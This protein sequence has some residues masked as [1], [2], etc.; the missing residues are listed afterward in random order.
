MSDQTDILR[1]LADP[2]T[3][4][5]APARVEHVQTHISHVFLAGPYVYK[6]KK[7][8]RLPFVDQSTVALRQALCLE[9]VR[10]NRRLAAP[11]YLGVIP[12]TRGADGPVRLG[13]AG[14]P[15]DHVVWMRRLPAEAMLAQRIT[16]GCAH[17][18]MMQELAAVL[19]AFHA[20]APR[21][22]DVSAHASPEAL[23]ATWDAT[24]A[25]AGRFAG[26]LLSPAAHRVLAEFGPAFLR[27]HDTL[28]RA[29]QRAE[30]A[31]E[32]HGDLHASH[33]YFVDAPGVY[34]VDCLEFSRPLRCVDVA[35]ELAFTI[36]D[37]E[38]LGRRDLGDT[39]R[40]AYVGASGD[41]LLPTVLPYYLVH[42]ACV[43]GSV[44]ALASDEPE[45]AAPERHA[46]RERAQA[47]FAIAL[48]NLWATTAPI[49]VAC[50]GR[51]GSGKTVLA[52]ALAVATGFD[53]V[54]SDRLRK[55]RAGLDPERPAPD[56]AALYT[57]AARAANYVA[58]AA[59][60]GRRLAAG[61]GVIVDATFLRR[62]DRDRLAQA[63]RAQGCRHVFVE[64][65][66]DPVVVRAR[67]A[68]RPPGAS[69][70][71]LATYEAQAAETEAFAADEPHLVVDTSGS[72]AAALDAALEGLWAWVRV[73]PS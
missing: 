29:R 1:A 5:H 24:L 10:L 37:L 34:I 67:L 3:Y 72:R 56:P 28:L 18:E 65:R 17:P 36:F 32:G 22:P 31:R 68:A 57:P 43:R 38:R 51:S 48:R 71:S 59:E 64:C 55:E 8:L 69:D 25:L 41:L 66:A 23:H 46:A 12:V 15:I 33:V 27:T 47:A 9:E 6:L 14:E 58:L 26:T 4:A 62:A 53:L 35:A 7:A 60:A 50:C 42:R 2:A 63:A 11:V 30:H 21:G 40:D 39:L 52:T 49:A 44:D 61:R 20:A 45:V 13:G 73:H 54:S 70:A 19:A 16:A